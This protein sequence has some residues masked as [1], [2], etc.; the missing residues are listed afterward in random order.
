MYIYTYT[1]QKS[2]IFCFAQLLQQINKS[3]PGVDLK[4]AG[5]DVFKTPPA[6]AN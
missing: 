2:S 1:Y 3:K 6:C 4:S 5:P